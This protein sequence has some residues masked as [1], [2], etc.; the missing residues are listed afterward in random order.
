MPDRE[1]LGVAVGIGRFI[2]PGAFVEHAPTNHIGAATAFHEEL[3]APF[4]D[5]F[6]V[7]ELATVRFVK[8]WRAGRIVTFADCIEQHCCPSLIAGTVLA[9]SQ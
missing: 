6:L 2:P 9:F 1:N 8:A 4:V 3:P 5:H 7:G